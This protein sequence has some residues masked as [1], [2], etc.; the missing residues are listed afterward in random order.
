MAEKLITS[1]KSVGTSMSTE[2]S[3][4][5]MTLAE[6]AAYVRAL[7]NNY[8]RPEVGRTGREQQIYKSERTG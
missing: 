4:R 7:A 8:A 3:R 6:E 5:R 2:Q 1:D